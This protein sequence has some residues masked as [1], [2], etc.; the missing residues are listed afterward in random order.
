MQYNINSRSKLTVKMQWHK[1][2]SKTAATGLSTTNLV[3][4]LR[5][6]EALMPE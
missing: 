5:E 6:S 2:A 4:F 1:V 3:D